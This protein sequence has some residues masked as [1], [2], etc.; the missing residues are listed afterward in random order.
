MSIKSKNFEGIT[1]FVGMDV[2]KKSWSIAPFTNQTALKRFTLSPPSTEKLA[3]SLMKQ[4]PGAIFKCCYEAGFSGFWAQRELEELGIETIIVN[5]ADIPQSDKDQKRKTDGRDASKIARELRSGNLEGIFI[6]STAAIADRSIVRFRDQLVKDE[7]RVKQRIKMHLH[8]TGKKLDCDQLNW[9]QKKIDLLKK[10]AEELNDVYLLLAIK[11][12]SDLKKTKLE[13]TKKIKDLSRSKGYSKISYLLQSIP[14]ISV[15]G[16]MIL[17]TELVTLSRFSNLDQLCSY[18]GLVPDVRN[19]GDIERVIGITR[20]SNKR[21]RTFLI[22][23]AWIAIRHD[24]ALTIAYTK[25]ANRMK[26]QKAIVKIARKLLNRIRYV[27]LNE[28]P[29]TCGVN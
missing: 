28:T 19:S 21:L 24:P 16:S 7:R 14:G 12:L 4:Y 10:H 1:I 3:E 2:H 22:E 20:R 8:F 23:S 27:W 29:Y 25:Y 17:M 26:G 5:A 9:S 11:Q 15:L 18:T 6:P 13:V